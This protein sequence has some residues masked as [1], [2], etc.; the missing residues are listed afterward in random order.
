MARSADDDRV[1]A[2]GI[3]HSREFG[4]WTTVTPHEFPADVRL[5]ESRVQLADDLRGHLGG[6]RPPQGNE[7]RWSQCDP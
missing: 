6:I 3:G 5:T 1:G 7:R 2:E 4:N